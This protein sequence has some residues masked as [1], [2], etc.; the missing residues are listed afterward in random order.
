MRSCY[1][2]GLSKDRKLEGR[3]VVNF[4]IF[5]TGKV[6]SSVVAES[7]LSDQAVANCI[8]KAVKRWT[9]P[10][11][12]GGENVIVDYPFELEPS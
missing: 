5:G 8:A 9:F 3:V 10:K 12:R 1:N 4:V 6:N 11:P 2:A 7:T